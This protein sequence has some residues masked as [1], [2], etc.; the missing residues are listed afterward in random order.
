MELEK[1]SKLHYI[2][3]IH[4]L[5]GT[6][7]CHVINIDTSVKRCISECNER[8]IKTAEKGYETYI[9]INPNK[10]N[11]NAHP[12]NTNSDLICALDVI[13]D[14][15]GVNITEYNISRAD[16]KF[17]SYNSEDFN[18]F[19]KLNRLLICCIAYTYS[20]KNCYQSKDLWTY[21]NLSIAIKNDYFEVENY[22]KDKECRGTDPAKNRLEVRSKRLKNTN[23][24]YEFSKLWFDR[25]DKSIKNY[26][27]V[28]LKYNDSLE[29]LYKDDLKKPKKNREYFNLSSFLMQYSDCI[30][31][32]KQLENLVSRFDCVSDSKNYAK[33]FKKNH[34]LEFF[35]FTDLKYAV[36]ELKRATRKFFN[37]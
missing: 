35:S 11:G 28:Q 26:I 24:E 8:T 14:G 17:D 30:F 32:T 25:W 16:F 10:I 5:S 22:D 21:E 1:R 37:N 4:T 33:N 9:K 31:C 6:I 12:L 15:L 13:L 27:N 20:V 34:K 36:N 2:A 23:L 29:K 18:L 19:A 7:N 3:G